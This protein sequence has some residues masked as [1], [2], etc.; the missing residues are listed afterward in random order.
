MDGSST[1]PSLVRQMS[2]LRGDV[3]KN[4]SYPIMVSCIFFEGVLLLAKK[5]DHIEPVTELS[6]LNCFCLQQ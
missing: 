5:G 2:N 4:T 3:L 6:D 1:A